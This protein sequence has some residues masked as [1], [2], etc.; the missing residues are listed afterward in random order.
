MSDAGKLRELITIQRPAETQNS[1]GGYTTDWV[2]Y[3]SVRAEVKAISGREAV[4]DHTL[5]GIS[6]FQITI[7]FREDITAADQVL[8]RGRTLNIVAPP[9]DHGGNRQWTTIIAG[10]EAIRRAQ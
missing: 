5:L 8:W 9:E 2:D 7:R 6:T 10:T 3:A 1:R 4:L